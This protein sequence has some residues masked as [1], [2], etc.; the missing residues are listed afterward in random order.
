[1]NAVNAV[2]N[3]SSKSRLIWVH[4]VHSEKD[5][6]PWIVRTTHCAH[7]VQV[8]Q[9]RRS[10]SSRQIWHNESASCRASGAASSSTPK[11][12]NFMLFDLFVFDFDASF[13]MDRMTW[14]TCLKMF[15]FLLR[16]FLV[17]L[18]TSLVFAEVW[19]WVW[20]L[21]SFGVLRSL[22]HGVRFL[23]SVTFTTGHLSHGRA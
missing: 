16:V 10:P 20:T 7:C 23:H 8:W 22:V 21:K 5:A 12:M 11:L 15:A 14:L 17:D 13:L 2:S 19:P 6:V 9:W 18:Q 4:W 1:M 3:L